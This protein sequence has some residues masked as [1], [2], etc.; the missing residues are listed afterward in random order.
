MKHQGH[1]YSSDMIKG[2]RPARRKR[3]LNAVA[4]AATLL[5]EDGLDSKP[6]VQLCIC[7][8]CIG[9]RFPA[10]HCETRNEITPALMY[11]ARLSTSMASFIRNFYI[12]RLTQYKK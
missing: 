2:A 11:I 10:S 4:T 8:R 9:Q 6:S 12:S 7:R 1:D 3:F 5:N